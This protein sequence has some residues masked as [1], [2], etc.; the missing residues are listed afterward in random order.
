MCDPKPIPPDGKE[1]VH[2]Q[3]GRLRLLYLRVD[4]A[5]HGTRSHQEGLDSRRYW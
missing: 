4:H 1:Q 2:P 3:L 5:H